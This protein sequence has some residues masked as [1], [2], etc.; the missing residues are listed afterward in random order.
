MKHFDEFLTRKDEEQF[1]LFLS[2]ESKWS[3]FWESIPKDVQMNMREIP[4]TVVDIR[5]SSDDLQRRA[6]IRMIK[7]QFPQ[8]FQ[9]ALRV[10]QQ[11]IVSEA[12]GEKMSCKCPCP[13][14]QD[15][16]C[17]GTA[18]KPCCKDCTCCNK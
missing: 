8:V 14:C 15:G 6:M 18:D 11:Q 9:K 2:D 13:H 16:C 17:N 10:H 1:H 12:K 4:Q 5:E 7:I 3:T